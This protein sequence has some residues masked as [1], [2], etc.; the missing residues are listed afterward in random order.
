MLATHFIKINTDTRINIY[1]V[2]NFVNFRMLLLPN[3]VKHSFNFYLESFLSLTVKLWKQ[4]SL[5]IENNTL[6]FYVSF[7]R[8]FYCNTYK[9]RNN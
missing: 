3:K 8:V 7:D 5:T 9:Q 4:V 2:I 6:C 1:I